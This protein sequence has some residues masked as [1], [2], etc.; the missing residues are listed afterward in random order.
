MTISHIVLRCKW[1]GCDYSGGFRRTQDLKR[2][3]LTQNI[4]PRSHECPEYGCRSIGA[5]TSACIYDVF[6]S[7]TVRTADFADAAK[8]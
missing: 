7:A 1:E 6:I 5:T 2:H 4:E 3:V 8:S